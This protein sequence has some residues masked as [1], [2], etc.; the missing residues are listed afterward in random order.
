MAPPVASTAS[1]SVAPVDTAE[2]TADDDPAEAATPW[3]RLLFGRLRAVPSWL[4]SLVVHL[5]AMLTLALITLP[6][7]LEAERE[8]LV[9]STVADAPV[10]ETLDQVTLENLDETPT[11]TFDA[12]AAMTLES[13]ALDD[14][15][16]GID[17]D[18]SYV[19]ADVDAIDVGEMGELFGDNGKGMASVAGPGGSAE[20]FGVKSG[21]RRFVFIVDS[22]NSMN[23]LKFKDA[24][25]ELVYAVRRLDKSQ[26]FYVIFFDRDAL[27]MFS[28]PGKEPEPRPVFATIENLRKLEAWLPTVELDG[29]TDPY[30]A[31]KFALD[32][33]PDAIFILSD[34][35]FTDRGKT[36]QFLAA[37]NLIQ[38]PGEAR[39]PKVV[40]NTIAFYSQTGEVAMKRIAEAY[41]GTYRFVAPPRGKK[42]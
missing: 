26:M 32:L 2:E 34:G 19:H 42:K 22:S 29:R 20:F 35:Q 7:I 3:L 1:N 25:E 8:L 36:E 23:G 41:K 37:N 14:A 33:R 21:G 10:L 9:V 5:I 27:R 13:S 16:A 38:E 18:G 24:K 39:R 30:D 31:V 15:A 17:G 4:V 6:S 11:E 40:I 12:P 28:G